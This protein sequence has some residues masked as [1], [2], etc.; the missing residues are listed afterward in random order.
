MFEAVE[1]R[2]KS[3]NKNTVHVDTFYCHLDNLNIVL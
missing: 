1:E 2:K 3:N